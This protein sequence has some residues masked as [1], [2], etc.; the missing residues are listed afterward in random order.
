V[1]SVAD[2]ITA[3]ISVREGRL[4]DQRSLDD[5]PEWA[6]YGAGSVTKGEAIALRK[7]LQQPE[8]PGML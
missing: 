5:P 6:D 3:A 4:F 1:E 2:A 8:A 7:H